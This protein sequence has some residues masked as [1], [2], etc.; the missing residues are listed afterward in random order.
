MNFARLKLRHLQCLVIV[1]QER[2]LVRAAKALALTQPAVSKTIAELEDIVGRRLL[3]RRRRG[4]E[5]TPA[6]DVLVRHA[7]VALRGL[8]EGLGLALDQPELDQLQVAVG[9]LPNMAAHL[10]P[11][12]VAA[13]HARSPSLRVRV[14][15][16][17]NAQLMTQLRQGEIDLVLGRLAQASAMA[18]LAFEQLYSEPLRLVARPGHPLAS[19]RRPRLDALAAYPLVMPVSG[20]LVR[21]T[22]DTF[23]VAQGMAP[24][25]CLIEATDTSFA[26]GLLQ[27][28]DAVW[29]APQGAVDGFV[30][31]GE[32]RRLAIDTAS[33][34]GPVGLTMR[35]GAE[36]GEG[37]RALVEAIHEVVRQRSA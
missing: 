35:R 29:F 31:R 1:A 5:L 16:G 21:Q 3:L 22:A 9:A 32:L 25:R 28:S 4:V 15:S 36:V 20:T 27:C 10:L 37:A 30:S 23:L 13:L 26:V 17:T 14:V 8:R 19:Q 34:E 18:D 7:V 6:A 24:P 33:T 2:N 11:V 12:A